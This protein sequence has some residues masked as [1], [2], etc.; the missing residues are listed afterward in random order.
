MGAGTEPPAHAQIDTVPC[1]IC[2]RNFAKDRVD[3]HRK[4]CAKQAKAKPRQIYDITQKRV[5]GTE[6]GELVK[7]GKPYKMN[8]YKLLGM[9]H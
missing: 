1:K 4:I 2:G 8:Q 3:T 7:A 9:T 6:A 5:E